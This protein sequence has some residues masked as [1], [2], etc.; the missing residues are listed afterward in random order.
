MWKSHC[1]YT[2]EC[3]IWTWLKHICHWKIISPPECSPC[4]VMV[5][6]FHVRTKPKVLA[7]EPYVAWLFSKWSHCQYLKCISLRSVLSWNKCLILTLQNVFVSKWNKAK[8][9]LQKNCIRVVSSFPN[10]FSHVTW[11]LFIFPHGM[12]ALAAECITQ[13][14]ELFLYLYLR[15]VVRNLGLSFLFCL[16]IVLLW[17]FGAAGGMP[18]PSTVQLRLQENRAPFS[19]NSTYLG[20]ALYCRGPIVKLRA[21]L[22]RRGHGTPQ[23]H[24]LTGAP[25]SNEGPISFMYTLGY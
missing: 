15:R 2:L 25:T 17:F 8:E 23:A 10:V 11:L 5:T 21:H 14:I 24:W 22:G 1:T 13:L 19:S 6:E 18:G 9:R 16:L 20:A 3:E 7:A 4:V 12:E